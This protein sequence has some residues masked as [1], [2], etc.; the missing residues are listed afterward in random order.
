MR[1]AISGAHATGKTTLVEAIAEALP[2]YSTVEEPFY[3]LEAEGY[4]FAEEP[5]LED[6]EVQL[7]RSIATL[8]ESG[9]NVLFD[10]CP[11]DFIAYLAALGADAGEWL[12]EARAAIQTLDLIILVLVET[13]DRIDVPD[14]ENPRLR[15]R[16]DLRLQELLL[17]DDLDCSVE[18][19][20]VSG[21]V[22]ARVG[23][24]LRRIEGP[25]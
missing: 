25:A 2:G 23:A 24:I 16:V 4:A 15:R 8:Q 5:S 3:L 14:E 21:S 7:A 22:E 19:L 13:P 20:V 9:E 1:I 10:R 12:T 6:F 17:D 11:A 18:V